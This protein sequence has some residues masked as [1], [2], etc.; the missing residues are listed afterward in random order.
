MS[1]TLRKWGRIASVLECVI[2]ISEGRRLDVISA[3]ADQAGADLLDV[4]S[5]AEHNRSV[6]TVVGET[7]PRAI[8][9]AAVELLDIRDHRGAHPRIGVV[10][11]VPFVPLAPSSMTEAIA[12]RD[13]FARWA[14]DELHVPCFTYGPASGFDEALETSRT[15]PDIRRNAFASLTPETGPVEPHPTA[16]AI[17]VGARDVLVAYNLWLSDGDLDQAHSIAA[18]IRSSSVRALGMQVDIDVQVSLNLIAPDE[19]GPAEVHDFVAARA[20]IARA[21]LVGLI[22][23]SVLDAVEATRWEELDVGPNTTIEARLAE[24]EHRLRRNEGDVGSTRS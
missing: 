9:R 16:G 5:C 14:A 21:E 7:A 23:R 12:A 4:H 20:R 13:S 19:T 15:L 18:A 2:N 3:I 17:A 10:D 22:P 6:L 24:R 11:V 8:T 1:A